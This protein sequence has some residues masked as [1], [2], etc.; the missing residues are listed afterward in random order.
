MSILSNCSDWAWLTIRLMKRLFYFQVA[1]SAFGLAL[2]RAETPG[3]AST[4]SPLSPIAFL[5]A[6]EWDA[7]LPDSA[8]GKKMKI[9]AQFTWSESRRTIRINSKFVTDGK[10]RPYVEGFYAWDPQQRVIAF[11]YVDAEGNLT[12]GTVR[13]DGEKLV[14][15]FEQIKG[16]GKSSTFVA[17]VTPQGEQSWENEISS[18]VGTELKPIVKVRYEIAK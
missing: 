12:K 6:H 17:N 7:K 13:V 9:H 15:E 8:D 16:D 18:R 4:A 11:W 1:F 3:A 14:H 2:A 10:A 5:T